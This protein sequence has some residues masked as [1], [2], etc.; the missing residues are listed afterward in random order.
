LS[1]PHG[2]RGDSRPESSPFLLEILLKI[3]VLGAG[4]L[5]CAIGGTLA[6]AGHDVTLINRNPAHVEAIRSFGLVM[7]TPEGERTVPVRAAVDARNLPVVDLVIVLVK[8]FDTRAAMQAAN[9]LVGPETVV[10]SLQNGL[11]HEEI[12]ASIVGPERVLAGKTYVGGVMLAPGVILSGV[13]GK[14]TVIGELDGRDSSR[15]RRIAEVFNA[16][17]LATS[18][19]P[20]I[21]ATMWDK[22]LVNVATGALSAV[23]RL[24]YG[25]LYRIPHIEATALA[26]VEEAVAVARAQGIRLAT[27]DPRSAWLKASAGLPDDFK[28]SMLQSLEKGSVTEID[29]I[30]GAVVRHGTRLGIPTPVNATLVACVKGIEATL[31]ARTSTPKETLMAQPATR[32]FVEHVAVRVKDVQWHIRFFREVLGQEVREVEG[33]ADTPRQYWTLGGMQ[34]VATPDFQAPPSNEAGWL[35]HLGVMVEDMEAALQAAAGWGVQTLP[36]GRN[37]LQLPDGLAVELIEAAPGSVAQYFE[38]KPR[39]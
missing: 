37:W 39:G 2:R 34:L 19:S 15:S 1:S 4:A 14:E 12:L 29:F 36:Q 10:L 25:P 18:V 17:G 33:P 28:T 24:P 20:D 31:S 30:N 35:A 32:S 27:S 8:S 9:N 38:V 13:A 5:G 11:G 6:A 7:R 26:A 22:L 23:T 3:A 21:L 16:A